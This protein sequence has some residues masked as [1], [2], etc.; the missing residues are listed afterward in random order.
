[1]TLDNGCGILGDVSYFMPSKGGYSLPYYWRTTFFG[2]EGIAE[3]SATSDTIDLT[4]NGVVISVQPEGPEPESYLTGFLADIEGT[5]TSE[6]L[7]TADVIRATRTAIRVQ[8]AADSHT[9]D[10]S[11]S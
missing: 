8:E 4:E 11:L 6:S 3:V 10:I 2:S 1:M 9:F 5:A 7:L